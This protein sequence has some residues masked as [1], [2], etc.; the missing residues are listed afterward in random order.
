MNRVWTVFHP[1]TYRFGDF[2]GLL[3]SFVGLIAVMTDSC[4]L[5][6]GLSRP[7]SAL[8]YASSLG[9]LECSVTCSVAV[10]GG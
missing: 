10:N 1:V 6:S 4:D 2:R 9:T 7:E 5:L 8:S 3:R